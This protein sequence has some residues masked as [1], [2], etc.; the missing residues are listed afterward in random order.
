MSPGDPRQA[1]ERTMTL[2]E[3]G[4][5]PE[6][7]PGELVDGRLVEDE[8]V[9]LLHDVV[10]AWVI[11]VIGTWIA[12]RGGLVGAS[13]TRFAVTGSRGRKPDVFVYFA[14][15]K[16]PAHGLVRTPPDI[17]IEVV[18]PRPKDARRDRIEKTADYAAFGVRLYW[19][20]DPG[21]ESLEIFE[22][23]DNGRY[24]LAL[25]AADGAVQ[26]VPG[27]PGLTLD[28]DALWA[29]TRRLQAE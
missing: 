16:G 29:E 19:I 13:D 22:R 23:D 17:M 2:E 18:S 12:E 11:R 8:D 28:L 5:L 7:E 10:V 9:G 15:R 27:C 6:D 21:V 20:L 1:E 3:W 25:G 24:G 26:D 4:D 14:G